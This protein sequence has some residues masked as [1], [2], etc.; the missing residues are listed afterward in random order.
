MDIEKIPEV[1]KVLESYNNTTIRKHILYWLRRISDAYTESDAVQL[2]RIFADTPV[3][4]AIQETDS[5]IIA[6]DLG[7]IYFNTKSRDAVI[8][9]AKVILADKKMA[10]K[11]SERL[12]SIARRHK[13]ENSQ[14]RVLN[15]AR[16]ILSKHQT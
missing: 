5:E 1:K 3:F 14:E 13:L 15:V 6:G 4:K 9:V 11:N 8:E 10:L 12:L 7:A 16:A 2:A